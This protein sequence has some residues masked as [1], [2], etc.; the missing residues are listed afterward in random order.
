MTN[1]PTLSLSYFSTRID[2]ALAN[3]E[4]SFPQPYF[5]KLLSSDMFFPGTE[6]V[7]N[8]ASLTS[9]CLW[10]WDKDSL[11]CSAVAESKRKDFSPQIS[12]FSADH[13]GHGHWSHVYR[14]EARGCFFHLWNTSCL[15]SACDLNGLAVEK[16]LPESMAASEGRRREP[17]LP[18]PEEALSGKGMTLRA[19]L[20]FPARFM[21]QFK[22]MGL[23]L[24]II[25]TNFIT[26]QLPKK[27]HTMVGK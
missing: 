4:P 11:L 14:C 19:V 1:N 9:G 16:E 25:N 2:C 12:L 3:L 17:P 5:L 8:I 18:S 13:A 24:I 6:K 27:L 26:L 21:T 10:A 15:C 22:V 7:T 23:L 20:D